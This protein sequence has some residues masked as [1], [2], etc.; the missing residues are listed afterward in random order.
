MIFD[1]GREPVFTQQEVTEMQ[2]SYLNALKRITE[3]TKEIRIRYANKVDVKM[4][5]KRLVDIE[6]EEIEII[7]K[8]IK[9]ETN[10]DQAT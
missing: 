9:I 7:E 2:K 10:S 5:L 1:K 6:Y 8:D 3:M 4:L